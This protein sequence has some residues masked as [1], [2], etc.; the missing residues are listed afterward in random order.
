MLDRIE[1]AINL[2]REEEPLILCL[3]N[4]VTMDF[5]ANTLLALGAKPIMSNEEK[6][7]GELINICSAIIINIGTLDS[8][9]IERCKVAVEIAKYHNKPLILDPVGAGSSKIRTQCARNLMGDAEV[10]RGNASEIMALIND[11]SSTLGVESLST[12]Q[13]AANGACKLANAL[14]CTI[15][16][17]GA[18]DF[19]TDGSRHKFLAFGSPLM[20]LITGMGCALTGVIAAFRSVIFDPFEAAHLATAY[21]GLCGNIAQTKGPKP[22][23]FRTTFIDELYTADFDEMRK[24]YAE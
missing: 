20:P 11:Q 23:L 5:V 19:I 10:I 2:L 1:K 17:S 8:T 7:I 4:Y 24:F 22:G 13:N 3:T 21:F 18:E 6:E 9:L 12:T 16:V 15:V 14:N